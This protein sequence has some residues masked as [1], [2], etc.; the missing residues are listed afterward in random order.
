M[1]ISWYECEII[2]QIH[3]FGCRGL[4]V[5]TTYGQGKIV[6]SQGKVREFLFPDPVGTLCTIYSQ[7]TGWLVHLR[8]MCL[9]GTL[10]MTHHSCLDDW[11][12]QFSLVNVHKG[13]LKQ[14]HFHLAIYKIWCQYWKF[15]DFK[16]ICIY[17]VSRYQFV[18]C[19]HWTQRTLDTAKLNTGLLEMVK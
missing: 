5:A 2:T 1:S 4:L 15:K 10:V 12:V 16:L 19:G 13:G 14:H 17:I 18:I 9:H 8:P 7:G 3:H 6:E 11:L